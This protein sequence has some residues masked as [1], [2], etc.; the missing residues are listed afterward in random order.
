MDLNFKTV[1]SEIPQGKSY[2]ITGNGRIVKTEE[3]APQAQ[4]TAFT[5]TT[6]Q[7]H[8]VT[9]GAKT[10]WSKPSY[11]EA[12]SRHSPLTPVTRFQS[13]QVNHQ[14]V[15][16]PLRQ[17]PVL[18][19]SSNTRATITPSPVPQIQ[20]N[21]PVQM[22]GASYQHDTQTQHPHVIQANTEPFNA[23]QLQGQPQ[24]MLGYLSGYPETT[25]SHY[26]S[27]DEE[28]RQSQTNYQN[29]QIQSSFLNGRLVTGT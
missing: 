18:C 21:Q 26:F 28:L 1:L 29:S 25:N 13:T 2:R 15:V 20:H 12:V 4:H 5:S 14:K 3:V 22:Y 27:A 19:S 7:S 24:T 8:T 6:P 9:E 10:V 17:S 16:P 11:S 23:S